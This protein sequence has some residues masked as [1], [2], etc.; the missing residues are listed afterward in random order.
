M[1]QTS[2]GHKM[3]VYILLKIDEMWLLKTKAGVLLYVVIIHPVYSV[4]VSYG[5]VNRVYNNY[6]Q[7]HTK[8]CF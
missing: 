4:E 2:Y 6:I 3:S 5:G 1:P 8:F 7:Q